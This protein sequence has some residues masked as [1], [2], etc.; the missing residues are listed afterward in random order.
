M[1]GFWLQVRWIPAMPKRGSVVYKM[2]KIGGNVAG[3]NVFASLAKN[4]DSILV[5][6]LCGSINLGFYSR[7]LLFHHL[8]ENQLRNSIS[9]VA[10]SGLSALQKLKDDFKDYFLRYLSIIAYITMPLAA[11]F[12]FFAENIIRYYLGA[13]WMAVV[14][15]LEVLSINAFFSSVIACPAQVPLALGYSQRY[16]QTGILKGLVRV[17]GITIGVI[18]WGAI[19]AAYG[20]LFSDFIIW[21]PYLKLTLYGTNIKII[22][23]AKTLLAPIAITILAGICTKLVFS[24]STSSTLPIFLAIIFSISFYI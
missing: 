9:T 10:F 5:G 19:G 7:G 2:I 15:Y 22:D 6:K 13:D 4:I 3:L 21:W 8:I 16:L 23:Y 20:L 24:L 18:V 12:Y 11:C 17:A 14:P 1:V